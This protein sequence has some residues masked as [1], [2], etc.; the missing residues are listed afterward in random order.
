MPVILNKEQLYL[1]YKFRCLNNFKVGTL[2]SAN[3]YTFLIWDFPE[4]PVN[5]Y[6]PAMPRPEEI[7]M[8]CF[9]KFLLVKFSAELCGNEVICFEVYVHLP[10]KMEMHLM[11]AVFP[12]IS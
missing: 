11:G 9:L 5:G 8:L 4:Y 3:I 2:L 1:I 12:E 10:V 7:Q 6:G